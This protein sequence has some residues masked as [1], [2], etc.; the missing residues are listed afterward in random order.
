M[1]YV[2]QFCAKVLPKQEEP[3]CLLG[4]SKTTLYEADS[5]LKFKKN[6]SGLVNACLV[7]FHL[8]MPGLSINLLLPNC[9]DITT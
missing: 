6:L 1:E 2:F 5:Q 4:Y 9:T 7:Q 3:N 8:L